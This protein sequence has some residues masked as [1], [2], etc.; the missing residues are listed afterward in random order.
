MIKMKMKILRKFTF[1]YF[2]VLFCSVVS[3]VPV[4]EIVMEPTFYEGDVIGFS[5]SFLSEQNELISY[6]ANV[7]CFGSAMA[8]LE[9]KET[10]LIVGELFVDEY[11]YG[12]VDENVKS[13]RCLASVSVLEPYEMGITEFFEV[14]GLFEF[15]F[16]LMFEKKVFLQNEDVYLDY[17]SS[18]D[19]V[20]VSVVLE[21]PDGVQEDIVLPISMKVEQIGTY[22]LRV[23][24]F[25]EGYRDVNLKEQFAVIEEEVKIERVNFSEEDAFVDEDVVED[26]EVKDEVD[27]G[28]DFDSECESNRCVDSTCVEAGLFRKIM[29]WLRELFRRY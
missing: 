28:C 22:E 1:I 7:N 4:I 19:D 13:G 9:V 21:S 18:V 8:L 25:K 15:S 14:S 27:V 26:V 17:E 11:R 20:V 23:V 16:D 24:A 10:D 5:Y 6:V 3:A 12:I 29:H 2:V